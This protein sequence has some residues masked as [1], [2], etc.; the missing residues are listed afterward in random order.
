LALRGSLLQLRKSLAGFALWRR[1]HSLRAEIALGFG[2]VIALMLAL[3]VAFHLGEQRSAA[4]IEKLLDSDNRM[5]DLS[6]RS[7]LAMYKA[8]DAEKELLLS[9]DQIGM[10]LASAQ[11]LPAMKNHLLD[12][13]ADLASLRDLSTD[14]QFKRQI[15]RIETRIQQHESGFLALVAQHGKEGWT[16]STHKFRQEHA[17]AAADIES[18]VQTL[19]AAAIRQALQARSDVERAAA[20]SRRAAIALVA[21]AAL[22]GAVAAQ[23]ISR[24]I[25][26]SIAQLLAFSRGIASGDFRARA[27]PGR[28]DEFDILAS[29]MNQMAEAIENSNVLLDSSADH[30]KHQATHDVL[31]GL[32]NRVLLED[33]LKQAI[34]YADRYR[35]LMTVV[36]INLDGFKL[37]NDSLSH[38]AGDELLKVM[39]A[40]MS[41]CLRSVDTVVR[42]SGDEFVIIL[43][44]Q[45]GNGTQVAPALQR[46]LD[47]IARP[48]QVD[49][50]EVQVTGSLG[51]A[52]YPA[53]G[54]DAEA[55]LMNAEAAMYRA[56]S[57]GR[58]NFQF[59]AEEMNRAIRDKLTMREGLRNAIV[60]GEFYLVYQPQV[61]MRS[62]RVTGAE[63]LIRWQ[64]PE[65]GLVA[66]VQFIPLAEE[67]GLI[68]PIGE[69][70]LRTACF[71]NKAW[72]DAGLPA[73][74]VSVN[75]SA[76]QFKERTLIE[77]IARALQD[78]GLQARFLELELTESMV[79]EDL[80]KA[81]QSMQ[82]LRVMGVQ[83]SIDD[84]GTGY[85]SLSALKR[86][87]I[88][89][90]KIDRAFVRDIPGDEG[91]K[92]IAKA[93]ISLGHELNLK[94]IAEG[95]ET[96]EQLEFL[97]TNGCDE[98]QGYLFSPPVPPADLPALIEHA[99]ASQGSLQ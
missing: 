33:R 87:P 74:S 47:D 90:L 71:Q 15:D 51:V 77:Q 79:M 83:F 25:I 12:M 40:R 96:E 28:A 98:M 59:Y 16:G 39:A 4:A 37:V 5:A 70:V 99:L 18:S 21:L 2:V 60:R 43:Y 50:H 19:H 11:F 80:E 9:V 32:P 97:R 26:G 23:V 55:L 73:F 14:P 22:V 36:F 76:R 3:G 42:T 54:A 62:G 61:E 53:D 30:L 65:Q 75:V 27:L 68:V 31:T 95:V 24:R 85:S 56:K 34:S 6:L 52:T 84:F 7:S 48:V 38:K 69:W 46:L 66:P 86:F 92:A 29:T 89:R 63:A 58:N 20:F 64:H 88:A 49:G 8:R 78:S 44:D 35:R 41:A 81:L 94:V 45:P 17:A 93:I 1:S 13:R 67:T 91:D 57:S 10:A 72:Q 82:A